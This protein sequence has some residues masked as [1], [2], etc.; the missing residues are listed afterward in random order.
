MPHVLAG[1]TGR[2]SYSPQTNLPHYKCDYHPL[3]HESSCVTLI[4]V[5]WKIKCDNWTSSP[6]THLCV[7]IHTRRC[8]QSCGFTCQRDVCSCL[9]T[10]FGIYLHCMSHVEPKHVAMATVSWRDVFWPY[11]H[12][13]STVCG[14]KVLWSRLQN[15]IALS[16]LLSFSFS[17]PHFF[18]PS[19]LHTDS[20]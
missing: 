11:V 5:M 19:R 15:V 20:T 3:R 6:V 16:T 14:S 13:P 8:M 1:W 18:S 10:C 17:Q 12:E 7:C 2:P 4:S 9:S